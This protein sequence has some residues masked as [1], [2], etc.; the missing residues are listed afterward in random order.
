VSEIWFYVL[1]A[2]T[3]GSAS[4]V[5]VLRNPVHSALSLVMALF[6]VAVCFASLGAHLVAALQIIVYAGA[7]MVL[8]LFVIMLLNLGEDRTEPA[9]PLVRV[10]AAG[11]VTIAAVLIATLLWKA[12]PPLAEPAALPA[13]FGTTKALARSLFNDYLVA[14]ELTSLLLLVAV[15]GA[16]VLARRDRPPGPDERLGAGER[17]A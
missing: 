6:L 11:S 2:L 17:G 1:A 16:V 4:G 9:R 12:L 8:F 3:V 7:V 5:I 10:L 15:V 14:F 13:G